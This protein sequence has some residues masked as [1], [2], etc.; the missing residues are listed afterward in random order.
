[1]FNL[2]D[3][4]Q[5]VNQKMDQANNSVDVDGYL[6]HVFGW[7]L[8]SQ[9]T[10]EQNQQEESLQKLRRVDRAENHPS[11]EQNNIFKNFEEAFTVIFGNCSILPTISVSSETEEQEKNNDNPGS[12]LY[13]NRDFESEQNP[14]DSK[15]ED[16]PETNLTTITV[17]KSMIDEPLGLGLRHSNVTDG[18]YVHE[19]FESGK[20][21]GTELKQGMRILTI[22]GENVKSCLDAIKRIKSSM[23]LDITAA[24]ND[25]VVMEDEEE[26]VFEEDYPETKFVCSLSKEN[27]QEKL[28]MTIKSGIN[29]I[30]IS[31]VKEGGKSFNAGLKTG[32]R[33]LSINGLPC[34]ATV[35][36]T[37]KLLYE[38]EG[39]FCI[40]TVV[41]QDKAIT[42]YG[43]NESESALSFEKQELMRESSS[44]DLAVFALTNEMLNPG[45]KYALTGE[46]ETPTDRE[47]L[48]VN[49]PKELEVGSLSLETL[50]KTA[51]DS[52]K[53]RM[54][55]LCKKK[56]N[57]NVPN[58]LQR[59][60]QKFKIKK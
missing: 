30:F 47:S 55:P 32:M 13:A 57:P 56:S 60:W 49:Q 34:P 18:I 6:E 38:A 36:E 29:G 4:T 23:T 48:V 3:S 2:F 39:D 27:K 50:T 28:G 33:I 41:G 45:V 42:S 53:S 54:Q 46:I 59:A 22:N 21:R 11:H 17:T 35:E 14:I 37:M 58:E 5:A 9:I 52:D 26:I 40:T 31:K 10:D 15:Q 20:F 24:P 8:A 19:I 1:M 51:R 7:T 12:E 25:E 16:D 43:E 44:Y